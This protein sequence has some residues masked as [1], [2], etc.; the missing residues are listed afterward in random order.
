MGTN[1]APVWSDT[2]RGFRGR[3]RPRWR[4]IFQRIARHVAFENLNVLELGAGE[5]NLSY[6]ALRAG[7][8]EVTLV[9][10]SDEAF[11]RARRLLR[12]WPPQKVSFVNANLL[13]VDLARP[14]DLV[15]SSGVVE[16]F[17]GDD[18]ARC[19][20][21]HAAHSRRYVAICIP[22]D[23]PFNRRRANDPRTHA[24]FGFW[25]TIPDATLAGLIRDQGFEIRVCERFRRSYGVPLLPIKGSRRV[26]AWLHRLVFDL[27]LA[28][29]LPRSWGGL[30]LVIGERRGSAG[31]QPANPAE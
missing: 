24:L 27:L 4:F 14:F 21:R 1:D 7:A 29:I 22:S 23:T 15:W 31:C 18:L 30:L 5:G 25:Q 26:Q 20:E 16:H 3:V 17:A 6:H 19:M 11:E 28:P 8:R 10:F 12:N 9:D 2:W 13:D